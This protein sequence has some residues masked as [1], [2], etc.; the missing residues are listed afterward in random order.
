MTSS[1]DVTGMTV[2]E[3]Q[4]AL[5]DGATSAGITQAYLDRITADDDTLGSYLHVDPEAPV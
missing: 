2:G 5:K 4:A 1:S 3:L